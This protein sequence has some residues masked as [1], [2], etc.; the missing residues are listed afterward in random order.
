MK[1][2]EILAREFEV[3]AQPGCAS[4]TQDADKV[5]Y[6]WKYDNPVYKKYTG[7]WVHPS[8]CGLCNFPFSKR[9]AQLA[10]DYKTAIVTKEMW[11]AERG[12]IQMNVQNTETEAESFDPIYCR[13]RIKEIDALVGSLEEERVSLVQAL[14]DEGLSLIER[15]NKQLEECKQSHEDMSD[16]QNWKRGDLIECVDG[17]SGVYTKGRLYVFIEISEWGSVR[18]T[19][20]RG[21]ENGISPEGFKWHSRPQKDV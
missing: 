6:C 4:V 1:L 13:D 7:K 9:I 17:S 3:W 16:W 14:E 19:D 2:V 10:D 18:C 11:E 8:G 12:K 20:D 5:V 21:R 15:I